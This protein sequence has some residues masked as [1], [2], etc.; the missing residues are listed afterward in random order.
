MTGGK[1]KIPLQA[2]RIFIFGQIRG[3][4]KILLIIAHAGKIYI[5]GDSA[6]KIEILSALPVLDI[7]AAYIIDLAVGDPHRLPHPVRGI[8]WMISGLERWLRRHAV[9]AMEKKLGIGSEKAERV[10][11]GFLA[12]FVA[13]AAF[14]AVFA[15][16]EAAKAVHMLL[17]HALNIYF[18]YTAFAARCLADEAMKVHSALAGNNVHEARKRL[19][20]LVGR[21]TDKL[22]EK[23][24]VRATV[25][26]VAENT[27][28]GVIS[29]IFFAA[30]GSVLGIAAPAAYLF[31]AVST[32][33][34]MVGYMN[35]KYI[36]F[37]RASAKL[38]DIL[39]WLPA[40][41]SGFIIPAAAFLLGK[42]WAESFRI[43]L[44]DR[45]NHKSPNCAYPEAAVAGALGVRLGGRAVYFGKVV[46]KP[47]IGDDKHAP[48]APHIKDAVAL[49]LVSSFI[50]ISL[51]LIIIITIGNII[52]Q[53]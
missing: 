29:P 6:L 45:R 18:I 52:K 22:D 44:R 41:L 47:D 3:L 50:S 16:L 48:V 39:N 25:E 37:G 34:S 14:L 9:A 49:M 27:V 1:L 13:F 32:L 10:S 15:L 26:T 17:F 33:D 19:S 12:C 11:G 8:G 24:I 2:T 36:N 38:D 53:Y 40:R 23:D 35:E 7:A 46:E 43:M 21:E 31:K 20:M 51:M 28:D 42:D 4:R 30:I 5:I